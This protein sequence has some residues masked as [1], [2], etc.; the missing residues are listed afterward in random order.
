MNT[1]QRKF[2][3]SNKKLFLNIFIM[4]FYITDYIFFFIYKNSIN[5]IT[6]FIL[7][8]SL[9]RIRYTAQWHQNYDRLIDW[10]II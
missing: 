3:L 9:K 2:D 1:G 7:S 10:L 5:K 4:I 6:K 8:R